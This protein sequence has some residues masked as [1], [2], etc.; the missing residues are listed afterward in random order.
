MPCRPTYFPTIPTSPLQKFLQRNVHSV[1]ISLVGR[2]LE[3]VDGSIRLERFST[4][5][6]TSYSACLS[7]RPNEH[8]DIPFCIFIPLLPRSSFS[9]FL[10]TVSSLHFFKYIYPVLCVHW[11]YTGRNHTHVGKKYPHNPQL[12]SVCW[13]SLRC[14]VPS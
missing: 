1:S 12:S 14:N 11:L 2:F 8:V 4:S 6:P 13:S 5:D 9:S 10:P 3:I 7:L